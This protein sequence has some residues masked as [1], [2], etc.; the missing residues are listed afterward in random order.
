MIPRIDPF[1]PFGAPESPVRRLEPRDVIAALEAQRAKPPGDEALV[2]LLR[3]SFDVTLLDA[4]A[5]SK[6]SRV[7][8]SATPAPGSRSAPTGPVPDATVTAAEPSD[9]GP[10][11]APEAPPPPPTPGSEAAIIQQMA[12]RS[13]IDSRFL[14]AI[15]RVE[16][17]RPGREFGVMSVPA[18]TYRDQARVAAET[19]RR[20]VE[21]FEQRGKQAVDP[22]SGRYTDEFVRFFSSRYAPIGAS[23]DPN[24][25]NR[26]HAQN[27]IRLYAKLAP[28]SDR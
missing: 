26:H 27:L 19:V 22:A 15:R 9:A 25:L 23:N 3:R 16:N 12:G 6:S 14:A 10:P 17:G 24:G 8:P 7:A 1:V 11:V 13:A 5:R 28:P 20:N 2:D 4:L 21:R 18:P